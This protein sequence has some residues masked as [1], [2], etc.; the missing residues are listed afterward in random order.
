MAKS[1]LDGF[2]A[3]CKD[4]ELFAGHQG[5]FVGPDVVRGDFRPKWDGNTF[6]ENCRTLKS[7][8]NGS[9]DCDDLK[10]EV[11]EGKGTYIHLHT[12]SVWGLE[13]AVDCPDATIGP[14]PY[15][16]AEVHVYETWDAS[17]FLKAWRT[18]RGK[19]AS[20]LRVLQSMTTALEKAKRAIE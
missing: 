16:G 11:P 20:L 13:F 15:K 2:P 4:V 1:N 6:S 10:R 8:P 18:L 9:L 12:T 5:E 7:L 17:M 3:L 14:V 19:K